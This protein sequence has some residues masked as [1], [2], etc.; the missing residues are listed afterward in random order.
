MQKF[1]WFCF[2]T[3]MIGCVFAEE[4]PAKDIITGAER[5]EL[6]IPGIMNKKIA[7]M[8]N[9]SSLIQDNHL[10]DSLLSLGIEVVKIFSPE[11]G[12]RGKEEAGAL[13]ENG[14]DPVT[15]IPVISL[16]GKNRKPL[17]KDL[18]DV[19]IIVFD[20][21]DVGTRFY[22]YISSLHYLMEACA[23]ND[24]KIIILDR[25]NPNGDYVDG[26]VLQKEF[27]SF[28]GMHPVPVVHGMTIGEYAHM[29]NGE[30]WLKDGIQCELE[31]IACENYSKEMIYQPPV[32]P[33][34]NLPDYQAI[35]LYPSLCFF[36]G[37]VVSIGR[38]TDFPFKVYGHPEFSPT[39]FSFIPESRPGFAVNP[40]LSGQECNGFDLHNY[41]T[42][43][44]Q[45]NSL[46]LEWLISAFES[47]P[48]KE[49]FFLP[50]F[51]LLAGTDSLIIQIESGWSLAEIKES[52]QPGL[53]EFKKV[54]EKYI[55]YQ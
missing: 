10:A 23:E 27:T 43:P 51:E 37:T 14:I 7:L 11:H 19:E 2:F 13:I 41:S 20:L 24:I 4:E 46:N 16:Y 25:P 36:E 9:Q 55:I 30:R 28:V 44:G 39:G 49:S 48:H 47:Y 31:V 53:A 6:Y 54:R 12:F 50:Y 38:G 34:P 29:I 17:G 33:S 1:L 32:N 26:P 40:K 15:Q 42:D 18:D 8:A 5:T 45:M 52:W 21:Q 3:L 35:R 22:T